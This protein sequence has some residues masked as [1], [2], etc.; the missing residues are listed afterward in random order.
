MT[1]GLASVRRNK[2]IFWDFFFQQSTLIHI[3]LLIYLYVPPSISFIVDIKENCLKKSLLYVSGGPTNILDVRTAPYTAK[4][5]IFLNHPE[6]PV[7]YVKSSNE[8]IQFF[9]VWPADDRRNKMSNCNYVF[10]CH[11]NLRLLW[12]I[13]CSVLSFVCVLWIGKEK[14]HQPTNN[15]KTLTFFPF[16]TR[17]IFFKK[18][19]LGV[20]VLIL[21]ENGED[22]CNLEL[23]RNKNCI[24]V[25]TS[26]FLVIKFNCLW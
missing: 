7:K 24:H 17:S 4:I 14:L 5:Y 10:L 13:A 12:C 21:N 1:L 19:F 20:M 3:T 2:F 6:C 9:L 16:M 15:Y 8:L 22:C 18:N 26:H 11:L 25:Y 23:S